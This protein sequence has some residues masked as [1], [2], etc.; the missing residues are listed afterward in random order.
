MFEDR[1]DTKTDRMQIAVP[2]NIRWAP[3]KTYDEVQLEN[4]FSPMPVKIPLDTDLEQALKKMKPVAGKMRRD[5]KV[6]YAAYILASLMGVLIPAW[7]CKIGGDNLSKP[8]TLSFSNIPG[9]LKPIRYKD[10]KTES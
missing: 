1:G 4:K 7:L 2:V 3:Y 5:F 10:T 8:L 6:T 9:I